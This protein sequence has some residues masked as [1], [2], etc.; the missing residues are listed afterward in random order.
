MFGYKNY[1]TVIMD[2]SDRK[3]VRDVIGII[4][5]MC[6]RRFRKMR[7][8]KLDAGHPT[9]KVIRTYTSAETYRQTRLLIEKVY[10]GLCTF[11]AIV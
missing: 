1:V 3:V 4:N 7:C 9:M 2:G 11:D 5:M 8:R 10:P 6:N